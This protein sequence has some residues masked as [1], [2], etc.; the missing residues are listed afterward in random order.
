MNILGLFLLIVVS[1]IGL[2]LA[3]WLLCLLVRRSSYYARG[4]QIVRNIQLHWPWLYIAFAFGISV[5]MLALFAKL[6]WKT[7]LRQQM[8][9]V[10]NFV[11]WLVR[12]FA[13]P[14][15][16]QIMIRL[17]DFGAGYLYAAIVLACLSYFAFKRKWHM[18]AIQVLCMGGGLALNIFLKYLFERSRPDLFQMVDAAGYSFPSGHAMV[19]LCF[20]GMLAFL[21]ARETPFWTGRLLIIFT[22]A[23]LIGAIGVS[24]IYLGV[25]YP[26]DVAAGYAAGAT[27]LAFCISLFLFWEERNSKGNLS[28]YRK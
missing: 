15:M 18:V 10:D 12:Y 27:W 19:S 23:L 16:D 9:A 20:Y 7:L 28:A 11:I 26:S 25:H 17:S 3:V 24:R 2:L 22:A 8:E 13:N 6:A 14:T 5:T 21:A 4:R 1:I